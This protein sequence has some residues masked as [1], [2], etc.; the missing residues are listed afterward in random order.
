[1]CSFST[2]VLS[3]VDD[4]VGTN[5]NATIKLAINEYAIVNP[6]SVNNCLDIPS[7]NTIGKNTQMVVNV[8]AKIAPA[9]W[10]DPLTAAWIADIP[11]FLNLYMFS[12]TTILLSTNIPTPNA[13]PAN[14]I[15]F[16]V[17]PPNNKLI[18]ILKAI[19]IVG[20]IFLK[21]SNNIIIANIPPKIK[22]LNTEWI[23]ILIYIP[24]SSSAVICI[25]WLFFCNS[26]IVSLILLDTSDVE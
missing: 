4:I 2:V 20:F 5:V 10:V 22:L 17:T 12:I 16:I 21:N 19:I 18:G 24:W 11:S 26:S 6:I 8:D 14:D 23:T 25:S 9:T 15:T 13:K 7:V 1:M 3:I